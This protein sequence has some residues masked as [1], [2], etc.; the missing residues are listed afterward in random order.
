VK[1]IAITFLFAFFFQFYFS[2]VKITTFKTSGLGCEWDQSGSNKILFDKKGKDKFYDLYLCNSDGTQDSCITCNSSFLPNKHISNGGWHPSGKWI[3]AVVER[4]KHPGTSWESLPG[5]GGWCDIWLIS[6]DGKK[7]FRIVEE[8]QDN[9]HGIICP[10]F[11]HD[12]KK[13]LWTERKKNIN[14]LDARKHFGLWVIKMADF[15]FGKDS[16]PEIKNIKTLEPGGEAFYEC[17]GFS[18]D[19]QQLV[20]CSSMKEKSAWLQQIFT[21]DTSGTNIKQLT[22]GNYNEHAVFTPDGKRIVW[23]SNEGNKNKGTDW[24][25]MNSDGT[26]KKK[27]STFNDPK[28]TLYEKHARYAGLVSFSPDGKKFVGGV[29]L[30]LITQEGKIVLVELGE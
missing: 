19:D 3:T 11:S 29:Q 15:S 12:G 10:R 27:L 21:M 2:Q 17:Y 30:S 26:E 5:I 18:P 1:P 6:I 13:L 24:W 23:M 4:V 25:I 20:F 16:I 22:S 8:P 9:D 14:I 7:G 28:S